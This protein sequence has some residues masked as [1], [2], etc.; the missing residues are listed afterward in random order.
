MR[1]A[2]PRP[3]VRDKA[4]AMKDPTVRSIISADQLRHLAL[5]SREQSNHIGKALARFARCRVRSLAMLCVF[6]SF[7]QGARLHSRRAFLLAGR[8][9]SAGPCRAIVASTQLERTSSHAAVGYLGPH[10]SWVSACLLTTS[11]P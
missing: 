4:H 9:A 6:R 1:T 3:R 10:A 8:E 2:S 7:V 11:T 5:A